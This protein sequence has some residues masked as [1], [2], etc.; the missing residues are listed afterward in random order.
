MIAPKY[1]IS[2]MVMG[3]LLVLQLFGEISV[4]QVFTVTRQH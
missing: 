3:M 1:K 4:V 2:L